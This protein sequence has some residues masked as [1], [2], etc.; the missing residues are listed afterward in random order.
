MEN[1]EQVDHVDDAA[2]DSDGTSEADETVLPSCSRSVETPPK[3]RKRLCRYRADWGKEFDWCRMVHNDC[4][5][6]ECTL[7][8][9]TFSVAHG[10]RSDVVQHSKKDCHQKA[11]R[12]AN[13]ARIQTFF[14]R[15]EP[16]GT[17]RQVGLLG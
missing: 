15:K 13:T 16:S 8:R 6:A 2:S 14:V 3:K 9:R 1:T 4:F 7:C 10:G 12:A 5:A 17:D 11:L